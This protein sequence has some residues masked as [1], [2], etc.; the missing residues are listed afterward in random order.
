MG[1]VLMHVE[2]LLEEMVKEE[3]SLRARLMENVDKYKKEAAQ[4]CN[5]LSLTQ[6]EVNIVVW[7][8]YES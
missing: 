7:L 3:D 2:N 5:E 6:Y 8:W 4:L 1:V